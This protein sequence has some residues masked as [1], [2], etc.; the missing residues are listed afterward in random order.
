MAKSSS[1]SERNTSSG[2]VQTRALM[3]MILDEFSDGIGAM[4]PG[5][6]TAGDFAREKGVTPHEAAAMLSKAFEAGKIQRRRRKSVYI[7]RPLE[8]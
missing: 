8:E 2:T 3:D 5:E 1:A 7:Y 6:F 4:Q